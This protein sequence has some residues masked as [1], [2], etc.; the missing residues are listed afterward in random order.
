MDIAEGH[1]AA[2]NYLEENEPQ[3]RNFNL[4]TG[5]GTSVLELINTF[6]KVNMVNIP[7][8]FLSRREGDLAQVIADNSLA[9]KYLNWHPK[10]NLEEMCVDG[11]K[12]QSL[13]LNGF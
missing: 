1:F 10:R 4:G 8:R 5:V 11:W 7:H 3:L 9:K 12:W 2:L 6:Q 13:N